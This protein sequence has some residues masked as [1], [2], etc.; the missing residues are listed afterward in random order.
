MT[1]R[2]LKAPM[3]DGC[4]IQFT[5][6]GLP[7][8]QQSSHRGNPKADA[9]RFKRWKADAALALLCA[10]RSS[11]RLGGAAVYAHQLPLHAHSPLCLHFPL[12]ARFTRHSTTQPDDDNLAASF[13]PCRDAFIAV[14][15]VPD[16]S[17][18]YLECEYAWE[19]AGRGKGKVV[20]EVWEE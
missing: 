12:R 16:D 9:A 7:P 10:I 3:P 6:Y 18:R 8:L 15:L 13:K 19:K 2:D 17:A 4:R 1:V 11:G 5:L 20:V 14:G